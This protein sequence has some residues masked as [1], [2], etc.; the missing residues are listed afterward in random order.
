M[1]IELLGCSSSR[2]QSGQS[3]QCVGGWRSEA[4]IH[5]LLR[6]SS[7]YSNL[8]SNNALFMT[9]KPCITHLFF[10]MV[11]S[12]CINCYYICKGN[13]VAHSFEA[14]IKMIQKKR[15]L[16]GAFFFCTQ[17]SLLSMD[18]LEKTDIQEIPVYHKDEDQKI[19]NPSNPKEKKISYDAIINALNAMESTM[20]KIS[21]TFSHRCNSYDTKINN[22]NSNFNLLKNEMDV[23]EQSVNLIT[24][25]LQMLKKN[26]SDYVLQ[27]DAMIIEKHLSSLEHTLNEYQKRIEMLENTK[28]NSPIPTGAF[29]KITPHLLTVTIIVI[30]YVMRNSIHNQVHGIIK[31]IKAFF[32]TSKKNTST[33]TK[34]AHKGV[35]I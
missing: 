11:P 8:F 27:K 19:I 6:S 15:L 34:N 20:H 9:I 23:L 21:E 17:N 1:G 28:N 13:I 30:L 22:I 32:F 12:P 18:D 4:Y 26:D 3:T 33:L 10:T 35:L 31:K 2:A 25:E 29:S 16:V 7:H 5:Y 24:Q 14:R